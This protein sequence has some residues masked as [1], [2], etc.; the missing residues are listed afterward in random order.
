[1]SHTPTPSVQPAPDVRRIC[2]GREKLEEVRILP[3]AEVSSL[4]EQ[5]TAC[6]I[7]DVSADIVEVDDP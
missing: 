4:K 2:M 3:S 5:D 1:M 7:V 6:R